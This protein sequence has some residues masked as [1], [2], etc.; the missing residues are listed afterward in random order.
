MACAAV[1]QPADTEQHQERHDVHHPARER[2][3]K[4]IS[5]SGAIEASQHPGAAD[6]QHVGQNSDGD[7]GHD[8]DCGAPQ[9]KRFQFSWTLIATATPW[10]WT[11]VVTTGISE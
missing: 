4:A 8:D 2:V 9:P 6:A 10:S 1:N 7:C 11:S 3:K 5:H